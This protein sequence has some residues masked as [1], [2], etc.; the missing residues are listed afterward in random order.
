MFERSDDKTVL[1]LIVQ[2]CPIF[3]FSKN[4]KCFP[5]DVE[6]YLRKSQ[7]RHLHNPSDVHCSSIQN[8]FLEKRYLINGLTRSPLSDKNFFLNPSSKIQ[9]INTLSKSTLYARLTLNDKFIRIAYFMFFP[10]IENQIINDEHVQKHEGDWKHCAL[11]IDKVTF[12]LSYIVLAKNG[13]DNEI[14]S[15][16]ELNYEVISGNSRPTLFIEV[17]NH[18]ISKSFPADSKRWFPKNIIFLPESLQRARRNKSCWIFYKGQYSADKV[19]GPIHY[20]WWNYDHEFI[21]Y[22]SCAQ[23]EFKTRQKRLED[24][25]DVIDDTKRRVQSRNQTRP[26]T[27]TTSSVQSCN[28]TS[29]ETHPSTISSLNSTQN[30]RKASSQADKLL[31]RH[32][33][34]E[35]EEKEVERIKEELDQ[36]LR[37]VSKQ[38]QKIMQLQAELELEKEAFEEEKTELKNDKLKLK[39]EK[40]ELSQKINVLKQEKQKSSNEYEEHQKLTLQIQEYQTRDISSELQEQSPLRNKQQSISRMKQDN[41]EQNNQTLDNVKEQITQRSREL[42]ELE[43]KLEEITNTLKTREINIQERE[44][45]ISDL[46]QSIEDKEKELRE[47]EANLNSDNISSLEQT[48]TNLTNE[49]NEMK[50]NI[51]TYKQKE[52]GLQNE[53][54]SIQKEMEKIQETSIQSLNQV[55]EEYSNQI[56]RLTENLKIREK[57]IIQLK[58][59]NEKQ[60]KIQD[61][62]LDKENELQEEIMSLKEKLIYEEENLERIQKELQHSKSIYEGINLDLLDESSEPSI[63]TR[64]INTIK[65]RNSTIEELKLKIQ[66]LEKNI[67]E[68]NIACESSKKKYENIQEA[69]NTAHQEYQDELKQHNHK[70]QEWM[71]N[72][73]LFETEKNK[74]KKINNELRT[75]N[76]KQIQQIR[77]IQKKLTTISDEYQTLQRKLFLKNQEIEESKKEYDTF[78]TKTNESIDQLQKQ[79]EEYKQV[80]HQHQRIIESKTREIREKE[81]EIKYYKS[82]ISNMNDKVSNEKLNE[83]NDELSSLKNK[84][85]EIKKDY[86][87]QQIEHERVKNENHQLIQKISVNQKAI[88]KHKV[89]ENNNPNS[90]SLMFTQNRAHRLQKPRQRRRV[91]G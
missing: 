53:L 4:E 41:V 7:L 13:K 56:E 91:R 5:I 45:E 26:H 74:Y 72:I 48:I 90:K 78:K 11:Y 80:I 25:S 30:V 6:Q 89:N 65:K 43:Q 86:E 12:Q 44:D 63:E 51:E 57:K 46:I 76:E 28:E 8:L 18:S 47:R 20:N 3:Y 64:I 81:T 42:R 24:I 79:Q 87:N 73:E 29:K 49:N 88:P 23:E 67:H 15:S 38:E 1:N 22:L 16:D 60:Q 62:S 37:D 31:E 59:E 84:Y 34:V 85:D 19:Y 82:K 10:G 83:L 36:R 2:N 61:N 71:N 68:A 55:K 77:D 21:D 58:L 14:I 52:T 32:R 40:D 33:K 70:E 17:E 27:E 35:R 9:M 66:D 54:S 75:T 39:E 69:M 50:K